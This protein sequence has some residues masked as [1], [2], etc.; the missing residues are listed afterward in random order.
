M[1][2][3]FCLCR[4][5][6]QNGPFW[7]L[8]PSGRLEPKCRIPTLGTVPFKV[9]TQFKDPTE[10]DFWS[11]PAVKIQKNWSFGPYPL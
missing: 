7:E 6:I 9:L 1:L 8:G 3:A 11:L 5:R 4:V 2:I 10:F